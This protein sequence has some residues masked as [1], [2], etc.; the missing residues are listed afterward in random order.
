MLLF[1]KTD[2]CHN[3]SE[4]SL[5]TKVNTHTACGHPSFTQCL[6]DSNRN[7]YN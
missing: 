7:E 4:N 5:T 2:T 6:C 3:N 1:E